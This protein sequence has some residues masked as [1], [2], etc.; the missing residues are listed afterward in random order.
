MRGSPLIRALLAF[1]AILALGYPLRRLTGGSETPAPIATAPAARAA[2][3]GS[4]IKMQVTFTTAPKRFSLRH[5][6]QEV[7]S[8]ETGSSEA[9][10]TLR[11][12]YPRE[13]VELQFAADFPDGAPLAAARLVLTDPQGDA[14]VKSCW[15]TGH[16]DEVVAFP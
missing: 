10:K 1:L 12:P 5:L 7:W 13:G 15:G 2:V 9:E 3:P 4:E 8:D 11:L 14:H 16:I 6:G